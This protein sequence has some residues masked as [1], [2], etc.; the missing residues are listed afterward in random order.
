MAE[1]DCR[2]CALPLV[3]VR[4]P[5]S[6]VGY[7]CCPRCDRRFATS[8]ESEL[9]AAAGR[10]RQ[11]GEEDGALRDVRERLDRF[12]ARAEGADPFAVLGLPPQATLAE[13]RERFHALA[14]RFHPDRGGDA[15]AMRRVIEAFDAVRDRIARSPGPARHPESVAIAR[16]RPVG[17]VDAARGGVEV[18]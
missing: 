9:R 14:L 4:A 2:A 8:Y 18:P 5:G 11:A 12:L 7:W 13:A 16:R 10:R 1:F 3:L 15:E 17:P 6:L